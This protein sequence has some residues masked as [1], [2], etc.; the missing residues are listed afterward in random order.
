[1]PRSCRP[2]PA[3]QAA[4][5]DNGL[6]LVFDSAAFGASSV[7]SGVVQHVASGRISGGEGRAGDGEDANGGEGGGGG[8]VTAL[9]WQSAG[10]ILLGTSKGEF[11]RSGVEEADAI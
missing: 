4:G 7:A 6:C 8:S 10:S 1:M 9:A 11:G 2:N 3:N 5:A